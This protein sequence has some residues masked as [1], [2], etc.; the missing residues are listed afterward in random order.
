MRFIFTTS[1]I[2]DSKTK[3]TAKRKTLIE[4]VVVNYKQITSMFNK[5]WLLFTI[6]MFSFRAARSFTVLRHQPSTQLLSHAGA[7]FRLFSV[8]GGAGTSIVDICQQKIQDALQADS[9]KVTGS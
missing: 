6:A 2:T 7:S 4:L 8:S 5:S 3:Q 1:Q 9:V